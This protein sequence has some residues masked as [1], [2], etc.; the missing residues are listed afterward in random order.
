MVDSDAIPNN[1]NNA[2]YHL[3]D[4][5]LDTIAETKTMQH[6]INTLMPKRLP[7]VLH[8]FL[9][10][11]LHYVQQIYCTYVR[12]HITY[13]R[14]NFHIHPFCS[15][16]FNCLNHASP[17]AMISSNNIV[18]YALFYA[19]IKFK[20]KTKTI[21]PSDLCQRFSLLFLY[22]FGPLSNAR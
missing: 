5:D 9:C 21:Q 18:Y 20:T 11:N 2:T 4:A 19:F 6:S 8:R 13:A 16:Y 3:E 7:L 17:H 1:W 10:Y 22:S 14:Y 15:L 12:P